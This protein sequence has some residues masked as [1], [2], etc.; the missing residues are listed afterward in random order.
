MRRLYIPGS[1]LFEELSARGNA[2]I[3]AL[4]APRPQRKK[5]RDKADELMTRLGMV[6]A[7]CAAL[8]P[9]PVA[10]VSVLQ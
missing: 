9:S 6:Q 7:V 5:I 3:T 8:T 10:S 4:Y 2:G 1:S